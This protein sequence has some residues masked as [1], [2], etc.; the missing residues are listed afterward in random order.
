MR[1]EQATKHV[2]ARTTH[3]H[4]ENGVNAKTQG[5]RPWPHQD[6][7]RA[8]SMQAKRCGGVA[9]LANERASVSYVKL[10][11]IRCSFACF[12]S[13]PEILNF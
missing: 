1:L 8:I 7:T 4:E 11:G 12:T 2:F 5:R 3:S 6:Q 13:N 10:L 9:V